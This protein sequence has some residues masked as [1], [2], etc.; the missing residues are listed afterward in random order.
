[1]WGLNRRRGDYNYVCGE[2]M[3]EMGLSSHDAV[4]DCIQT[5]TS[6]SDISLP[7]RG[8]RS[9]YPHALAG[10]G[11]AG[12]TPRRRFVGVAWRALAVVPHSTNRVPRLLG[13][14]TLSVAGFL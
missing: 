2:N 11:H 7:Q 5:S 14:L 9:L 1:M 4:L 8:D 10:G 13:A 6:P 12:G 3:S